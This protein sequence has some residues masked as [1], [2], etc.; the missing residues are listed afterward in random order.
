MEPELEVDVAVLGS[1]AAGLVAAIAAADHGASV[2]VFEK[3]EL[4]GGTSAIS[5]G[6]IWIPNNH[7]QAE[8]GI[9]DSRH[10]ALAY[11]ESL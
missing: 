5:G 4:I 10:E 1:G 3:S 7:L 2:T 11:F 9:A 8:A 6:I